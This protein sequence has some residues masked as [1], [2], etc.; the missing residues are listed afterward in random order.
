MTD[1]TKNCPLQA[2]ACFKPA[3]NLFMQMYDFDADYFVEGCDFCGDCGWVDLLIGHRSYNTKHILN[4]YVSDTEE[5]FV[6]AALFVCS[7]SCH[8]RYE[9]VSYADFEKRLGVD[10]L[11]PIIVMRENTL[12]HYA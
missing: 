8:K 12:P 6:D 1:C 11:H 3:M 4:V 7:G 2:T 10:L 9:A 5:V